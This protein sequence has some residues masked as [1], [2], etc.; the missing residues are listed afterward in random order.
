[1]VREGKDILPYN[2]KTLSLTDNTVLYP[3]SVFGCCKIMLIF[4]CLACN[5]GQEHSYL[6]SSG[7]PTPTLC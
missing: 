3:L 4:F 7:V 2:F 1:V 6:K 5:H